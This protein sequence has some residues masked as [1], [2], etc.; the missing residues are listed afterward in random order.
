M[1]TNPDVRTAMQ[2]VGGLGMAPD[3]DSSLYRAWIGFNLSHSLGIV[4]IAGVLLANITTGLDAAVGQVW[5][6]VLVALV[7]PLY[8]YLAVKYWFDKPR[9][10]IALATI[11]LWAG[12]IFELL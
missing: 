11:L 3:I 12:V 5:F 9:D 6:L 4:A 1:P 7:P 2:Q 8:L 10:G